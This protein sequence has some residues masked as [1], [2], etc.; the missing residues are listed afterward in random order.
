MT[1]GN[2]TLRTAKC[3]DDPLV[4]FETEESFVGTKTVGGFA[5]REDDDD[6]YDD[7]A[8]KVSK[9]N[10]DEYDTVV[11]EHASDAEDDN[12]KEDAV[13]GE[14]FGS[15]FASWATSKPGEQKPSASRGITSDGRPP[16]SGFVLG[17]SATPN[18]TKR[19][20]GPDIPAGYEPKRHEF[21]TDEH[22]G[23]WKDESHVAQQELM[24]HR[25]KTAQ[26]ERR[27]DIIKR[28]KERENG[29]MAGV[30]FAGLAAAMK[31]RFTSSAPDVTENGGP[32]GLQQ[33]NANETPLPTES[34]A[35][36]ETVS[37]PITIK[38]TTMMFAP[39][40]LLCKRFQVVAPAN[41]KPT[42][43]SK[44][45]AV[46]PKGEASYFRREILSKAGVPGTLTAEKLPDTKEKSAT[47]QEQFLDDDGTIEDP[48]ETRPS[49]KV[50]ESI[51]EPGS[52]SESE[53]NSEEALETGGTK[54]KVSGNPAY[55]L[56]SLPPGI[57]EGVLAPAESVQGVRK[58]A[59][60][61]ERGSDSRKHRRKRSKDDDERKRRRRRSR[62][63]SPSS[64][65]DGSRRK[66]SRKREEKK[67]RKKSHKSSRQK[68]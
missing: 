18:M 17:A 16:L 48:S 15:V 3:E 11:Y 60:E 23:A 1:H 20:P 37:K 34:V 39:E 7:N 25:R 5:L 57:P 36:K 42:F 14:E 27:A 64:S 24:E 49:M 53:D 52:E 63:R 65:S 22:P 55:V 41:A 58:E 9:I 66:R 46:E 28:E 35:V 43:G 44:Q 47:L 67:K 45:A 38:R 51:F 8:G 32:I 2:D 61:G 19:Y 40:T 26:A 50:L 4:S 54:D 21:A 13:T 12:D 31:N 59:G 62:S 6:V 29:P 30:A 56:A 10:H 68:S 33:P